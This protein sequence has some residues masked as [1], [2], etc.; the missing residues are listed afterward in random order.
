MT[1]LVAGVMMELD[2]WRFAV[3][4]ALLIGYLYPAAMANETLLIDG[5]IYTANPSTPWVQALSIKGTRIEA[6][7]T[8]RELTA[9]RG[10]KSKIIDLHGRTV[11]PG[12]VDSHLHL[13][14]GAR[15]LHGFN[16][17]NP[18]SNITPDDVGSVTETI[19]A[20]AATHPAD[21]VLFGR[22]DFSSVPPTTPTHEYLDRIVNDRPV[23]FLNASG[24]ALWLN[25]AALAM[26]GISDQPITD[27]EEERGVIR[28]AS[29]HPS[30]VVLEAGMRPVF[31]AVADRVPVEDT[32]AMLRAATRYLNRYGIT[33]VVNAMGNLAELRLYAA[34]KDHGDLT[35]RTRTALGSVGQLHLTPA[36]LHD[37]EEAR[38]LYNDRWV[39]A[40]LVKLFADGGSGLIPPL[41]YEPRQY[42]ELVKEFDRRGYQIMTHAARD[43]SVRMILDTYEEVARINGSRD[44]R[45]RIE[46][47][48]LVREADIPRFSRLSTIDATQP[49][50]CCSASGGQGYDPANHEPTD[51]WRSILASGALLAF[52]SDWPSTWP[53]DPFVGMQQA[54]TRQVWRAENPGAT[55]QPFDGAGQGG[56]V[57]TPGAYYVPEES[58]A[59][60]DAVDAYTRGSAY[61]SFLE[62]TVGTLEPG[63]EADLV[64]LSQDLF[65]VPREQIGK[66]HALMT[67]VGGKIV[68]SAKP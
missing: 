62:D 48:F 27:P 15:A 29:G 31:R 28:D 66:T 40:N 23:V 37:L 42:A 32:L 36:F 5:H 53:P 39:S 17:C 9:H 57:V 33:S 59:V 61:A 30:G 35:V 13:I 46:H 38:R 10:S 26:S 25:A 12:I 56:A 8:D 60:T 22:G 65:A 50:A 7:G 20:Y 14:E 21:K 1:H 18:E 67:M 11:I 64:V 63:K 16:L 19:R 51:R 55:G 3:S 4:A 6:V 2:K 41:V 54:T 24:H 47:A 52:S 44:R 45:F 43:D 34:L 58:I 68:F 49:V